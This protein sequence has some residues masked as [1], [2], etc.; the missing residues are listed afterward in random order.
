ME[1]DFILKCIA[2]VDGLQ[3][4]SRLAEPVE[5]D[6]VYN[7]HGQIDCYALISSNVGKF[8]SPGLIRSAA[9]GFTSQTLDALFIILIKILAVVRACLAGVQR[10]FVR[11]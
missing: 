1:K 2:I 3:S 11:F 10:M 5:T 7:Q 6:P 8:N 9:I 4:N